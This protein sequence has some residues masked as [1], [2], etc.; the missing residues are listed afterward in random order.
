MDLAWY[1][2]RTL[3]RAEYR[4][5]DRLGTCGIECFLPCTP[6]P[7][8]RPGRE[9]APLFPGYLFVHY[10]LEAWGSGPLRRVPGVAGLVTFGQMAPSIPDE[11]VQELRHRVEALTANGGLWPKY[12]PGDRVWVQL[13][14]TPSLAEVVTATPG[15]KARMRVLMEI[16]G[17]QVNAEVPWQYLWPAG[18]GSSYRKRP[19]GLPPRR[20]RGRGRWINGFG[21]RAE[22]RQPNWDN[23][24]S[25]S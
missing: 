2:A 7:S 4:A 17:R 3:P 1:V 13:G 22:A 18:D 8:A 23:G 6:T 10:D 11:E 24:Y 14:P 5:R 16:M 19:A 20:T 12:H 21:P 9:E 25:S 15:S